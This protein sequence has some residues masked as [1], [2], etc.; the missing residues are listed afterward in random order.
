MSV[1]CEMCGLIFTQQKNLNR[2]Y[3]NVHNA[4]SILSNNFETFI[5]KC[6][7]GCNC[8][9]KYLKE[10]REHLKISHNF[11]IIQEIHTFESFQDFNVWLNDINKDYNSQYSLKKKAT[12]EAEGS[13]TYYYYCNRSGKLYLLSV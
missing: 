4:T 5:N 3:K 6:L 1:K 13:T 11:E 7:D 8:S 2:H 12:N 10:L 9:F